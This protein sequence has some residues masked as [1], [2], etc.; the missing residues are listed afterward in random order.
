MPR[1]ED[2]A[3][4]G[5][6]H[7]RSKRAL[8]IFVIPSWFPSQTNPVA[9]IFIE[10]QVRALALRRPDWQLAVST[11]GQDETGIETRRPLVSALRVVKSRRL[12]PS[13]RALEHNAVIYATPVV[14]WTPRV[15]SGRFDAILQANQAN[16][17]RARNELGEIDLIHAHT[18]F[19]AGLAAMELARATGL[20][21][22]VT[23]HS[24]QALQERF[25]RTAIGRRALGA[26]LQEAAAT[27][28][29]SRA[30]SG[31]LAE[32]GAP[33]TDVIPNVV[34]E[35]FF[36]LAEVPRPTE[37]P[38]VFTLAR[39]VEGKGVAELLE[40]TGR[41]RGAGMPIELRIGGDGPRRKEWQGHV[42]ALGLDDQVTFLGTLTRKD[43]REELWKCSC[44]A[45]ASEAESFGVV[46]IEALACGRP[47]VAAR[48]G[49][50]EEIVT[51]ENGVL[52]PA[53][54]VDALTAGLSAVLCQDFDATAI[55]NDAVRR[56]GSETVVSELEAV[57][58][59]VT[60]D[61]T[62]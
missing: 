17:D 46:Y 39:L 4:G 54:D 32:A 36:T 2:H 55:R 35:A 6:R 59:R 28:A 48:S 5:V 1:D 45:L 62:R 41:L 53:R 18:A 23:E 20:R 29:V 11:W 38:R 27:I 21:Y 52:V 24:G 49:G 10:D 30:L 14:H 33:V 51:V 56:F 26:A 7:H 40:A 42:Q 31:V 15:L 37:R 8:R 13:T 43:V 25:R 47:V 58:R 3:T 12:R 19:P 9:G 44:F 57:Y 50:P 16:L 60:A 61:G 34:D 22:V